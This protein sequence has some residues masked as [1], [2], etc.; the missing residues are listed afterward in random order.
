MIAG[1]IVLLLASAVTA[2]RAERPGFMP[3]DCT[4]EPFQRARA[5]LFQ[6]VLEIDASTSGGSVNS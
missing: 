6:P 2:W 4:G 5:L 1:A 3:S